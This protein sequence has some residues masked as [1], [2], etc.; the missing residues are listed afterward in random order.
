MF[1]ISWTKPAILVSDTVGFIRKLPHDLVAS[2]RSTLEEAREAALLL[3]VVDASDPDWRAQ[4]EVTR[5]VLDELGASDSPTLLILNKADRLD[6]AARAACAEDLPEAVVMSALRRDD[7][8]TLHA[9][10]VAFFERE[11]INAELFVPYRRQQLMH[12]I[13]ESCRVMGQVVQDE[14][15]THVVVRAAPA[16]VEELRRAIEG[17]PRPLA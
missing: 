8:T 15:G 3:H 16:L 9:R 12:T 4:L 5:S 7:V 17:D 6:A 14:A 11:M 13:H 10:I 2:F 1:S